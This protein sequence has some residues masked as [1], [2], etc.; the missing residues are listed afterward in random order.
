MINLLKKFIF[1]GKSALK[2]W[3]LAILSS[4][5]LL[6]ILTPRPVIRDIFRLYINLDFFRAMES[7]LWLLNRSYLKVNDMGIS[8]QIGGAISDQ[9]RI[10]LFNSHFISRFDENNVH[11]R[12]LILSALQDDPNSGYWKTLFA[13]YF[14]NYKDKVDIS[15]KKKVERIKDRPKILEADAIRALMDFEDLYR[16]LPGDLFLVSGTFLGAVREGKF[17]GHDYDIDLGCFANDFSLKLFIEAIKTS[18]SLYLKEIGYYLDEIEDDGSIRRSKQPLIIKILHDSY[19]TIDLFIHFESNGQYIHGSSIHLWSNEKFS[20]KKYRFYQTT[21]MGAENYDLYLCENYGEWRVEK[22]DFDC[23]YDTPNLQIPATPGAY[24]YVLN[25][26][27]DEP[28]N[29]SRNTTHKAM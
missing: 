29:S 23:D 18:D 7:T 20:L 16:H 9:S 17:L 10:A 19:I 2:G 13:E 26:F 22:K 15:N 12:K 27:L 5:V 11:K 4:M 24:L 1:S 8:F 28:A 25:E 14:S 3:F 6:L 21:C